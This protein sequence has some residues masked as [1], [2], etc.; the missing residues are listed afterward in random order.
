MAADIVPRQQI[1]KSQMLLILHCVILWL[2]IVSDSQSE[3]RNFQNREHTQESLREC[4]AVYSGEGFC[5]IVLR[6]IS[7]K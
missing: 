7:P 5:R 4:R 1:Q 6:R 3:I 2:L